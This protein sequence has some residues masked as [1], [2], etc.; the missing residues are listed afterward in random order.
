MVLR[1]SLQHQIRA[2]M[3]PTEFH[4]EFFPVLNSSFQRRRLLSLDATLGSFF[5]RRTSKAERALGNLDQTLCCSHKVMVVLSGATFMLSEW[6]RATRRRQTRTPVHSHYLLLYIHTPYLS[7]ALIY[8][9]NGSSIG[10][11]AVLFKPLRHPQPGFRVNS[12]E[13]AKVPST[14]KTNPNICN[15]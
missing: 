1:C 7:A 6:R 8:A 3:S 5:S 12:V 13:K 4:V 2:H 14:N 9:S 10:T 15:Q 11:V